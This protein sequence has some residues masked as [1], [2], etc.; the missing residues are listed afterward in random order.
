MSS[1]T[2]PIIAF[3]LGVGEFRIV[4]PEAVYQI[5][6]CHDLV[7]AGAASAA[8]AE[9]PVAVPPPDSDSG[10]FFKEISEEL[11]DKIG[12]LARKLSVSVEELPN[13]M[14]EADLDQ[15]GEQLE[16]AKGQ[17]EE[18]VKITERASMSIMDTADQIQTDM[19]QLTQQLDILN[20]LDLI[21]AGAGLECNGEDVPP[22]EAPQVT[23]CES[24]PLRPEFFDKLGELKSFVEKFLPSAAPE[25]ETAGPVAPPPEPAPETEAAP[26]PEPEPE[27]A[28]EP[29]TEMVT[30][31]RFDV[32]VVFQTLY[33]LCTNE[34]VKDHIK[35]M[36]EE[37]AAEFQE[38]MIAGKLSEMAPDVD[39]EDGFYNFPI[40][41]ILK[42]L[43][44]AT[45]NE[46]F[47]ATLKKMNQ[48]AASIF[49]DSVLPIEGESVEME[50]AVP[51]AAAAA[52]EPEPEPAPEPEPVPA[53]EEAAPEAA[54][55]APAASGPVCSTDDVRTIQS[56]IAE[57]E[58][59]SA[60][61]GADSAAGGG[62]VV[63]A[64]DSELYTSIL[65]RD[66]DTIVNTVKM[67][68]DLIHNTGGNLTSILESLSFQDLSGQRIMKVVGLINDIQKQLL[69]ILV[70]VDTKLKVHQDS[71]EAE[72]RSEKTEKMAQEEVDKALE[73]L[74]GPA[75][76]SELQGPG[77]ENRLDQGAV[78]DLLAQLGF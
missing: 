64:G 5:K 53:A 10:P 62:Q 55:E 61:A 66:R 33:E 27:A 9:E 69:S 8:V 63:A 22:G 4:T 38:D 31:T 19:D 40:I 32:D 29:A 35:K 12:R 54:P 77:A 58:A 1:S 26:E 74:S 60:T 76:P 70:S 56:L 68:R 57:I 24:A 48:T 65:T 67:A 37:K 7:E 50:V 78:N 52:P 17:L 23:I 14:A 36:R 25:G 59:L 30:V 13:H 16:N 15:T 11:F 3:E 75:E 21:A 18:I 45:A 2:P 41:S 51:A 72:V 20:E 6:V 47:R 44:A 43:Y 28:P 42:T 73:K 71:G 39:E 34:S 49:L 46:D